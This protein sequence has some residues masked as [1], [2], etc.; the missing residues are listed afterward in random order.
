MSRTTVERILVT[1]PE[2]EPYLS[3]AREGR[4][5]LPRCR[6]C[7]HRQW[8]PR[9]RCRTCHL[10]TFDTVEV[11]LTGR[12]YSWTTTHRAPT[13]TLA[14]ATPYTVVVVTLD[15]PDQ[16][17]DDPDDIRLVGR[18]EPGEPAPRLAL[19]DPLAGRVSIDDDGLPVLTWR[20]R[21]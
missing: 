15:Q 4:F 7:T 16:P 1:A 11:R 13:P 8:P 21:D 18:W 10:D 3:A 9:P 5:V 2:L 6:N 14:T 19:N 17:A 20:H 12:L